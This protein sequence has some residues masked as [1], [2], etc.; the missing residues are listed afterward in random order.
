[1]KRRSSR[2]VNLALVVPSSRSALQRTSFNVR[3][4][5]VV[6]TLYSLDSTTGKPRVWPTSWSLHLVDNLLQRLLVVVGSQLFHFVFHGDFF[7]G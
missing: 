5:R 2:E 3:C 4:M 1:M 6:L 7:S